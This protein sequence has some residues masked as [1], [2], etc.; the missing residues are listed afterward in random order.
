[1]VHV[2]FLDAIGRIIFVDVVK[3]GSAEHAEE[4]EEMHHGDGYAGGRGCVLASCLL[5]HPQ[6]C[7]ILRWRFVLIHLRD[8]FS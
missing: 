5:S 2:I 4:E 1:M 3:I 6:Q 7:R 8:G